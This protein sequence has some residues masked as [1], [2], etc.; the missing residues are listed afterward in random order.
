M[1]EER[2]RLIMRLMNIAMNVI[3]LG[4]L[5]VV[6]TALVTAAWLKMST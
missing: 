6:F 1:T 2:H 4:A 3:V 5:A